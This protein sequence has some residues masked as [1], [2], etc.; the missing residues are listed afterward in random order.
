MPSSVISFFKYDAIKKILKIVYV[1]GAVYNYLNVPD[2]V[3]NQFTRAKS[4]GT[5]LNKHIKG[6]FAY[7]KID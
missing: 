4:K 3:Y 6:M 1:S 5:Y 2:N 7:E